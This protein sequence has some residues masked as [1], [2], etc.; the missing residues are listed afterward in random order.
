[1]SDSFLTVARQALITA[2]QADIQV[3][4]DMNK[5]TWFTLDVDCRLPQAIT[6]QDAPAIIIAPATEA[7][8]WA[9]NA[10]VDTPYNLLVEIYSDRRDVADVERRVCNVLRAIMHGDTT[11]FGVGDATNLYRTDPQSVEF[12]RVS[13]EQDGRVRAVYWK[14]QFMLT[15]T[16][17]RGPTASP[18]I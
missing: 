8:T 10:S 9:T 7:L 17:R 2:L 3:A 13:E 6:K 11:N 16:F 18:L 5:G 14:A 15:L 4:F 12:F 1:M